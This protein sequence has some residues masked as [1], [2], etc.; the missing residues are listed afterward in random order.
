MNL[1]FQSK[2]D[3]LTF[4]QQKLKKGKIEE[5]ISF[6]VEKWQKEEKTILKK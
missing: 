6:T 3:T 1:K 4:L 5:I 2:A